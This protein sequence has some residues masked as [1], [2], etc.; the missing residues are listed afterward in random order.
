MKPHFPTAALVQKWNRVS[1]LCF[2]A[3]MKSRFPTAAF[4]IMTKKKYFLMMW[5]LQG[6]KEVILNNSFKMCPFSTLS[7]KNGSFWPKTQK[8]K[9]P[10]NIHEITWKISTT[11]IFVYE[12]IFIALEYCKLLVVMSKI[13]INF[14]LYP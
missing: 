7:F 3:K 5:C 9:S 2:S 12:N 10:S 1:Q 14:N 11:L 13:G 8:Y 4:T 6:I